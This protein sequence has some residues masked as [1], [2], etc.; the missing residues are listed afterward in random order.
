MIVSSVFAIVAAIL[1]SFAMQFQK[2]ALAHLDDLTG[3]FVSV[4]TMALTFWLISLPYLKWEYWTSNAVPYFVI[5]GLFFPALGQRFQIAA[6]KQVGP[7][8]TAAFGSFLP[9]FAAFP[10]IL[11]LGETLSLQQVV[12]MTLLI[13]GLLL[14]AIARGVNWRQRAFYVLLV[15]LGAAL[16]RAISQPI[17]KAGYNL[18]AEPLFATVV[19]TTVSTVVV[20]SMVSTLGS[21]RL[22]L[23]F[24]RGHLLFALNGLLIGIGIVAL[25]LALNASSVSLTASLVSTTPI[26]TLVLGILVF[27]NERLQ[28][29]H[30]VVAAL[31]CLGALMIVNG[32]AGN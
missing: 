2:T 19:M 26:W 16:A 25:Q 23:S 4:A 11:F 13:G 29:W 32:D 9:F 10:A 12:G 5:A 18:L 31:V 20:G 7:A 22:V 6:V 3:T 8:L 24:G 1:F 17:A 14:A 27:K 30:G 28:A 15:P 21:P